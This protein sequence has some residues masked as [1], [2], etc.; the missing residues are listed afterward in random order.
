LEKAKERTSSLL[1]TLHF[2]HYKAVIDNDKL[3]KMH[4]VFVDIT[5]NSG[6]SP[7]RWQKGLTVMLEKKQ[8]VILVSKLRAILLM[9]ADFNFAHKT[10]F[11]C[12]MMHFAE[13]RNNIAGDCTGS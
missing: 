8:G 13:D 6:Y 3:N 2:G 4:A 11:G 5:I 9:E 1:S 12:R 10:I 7:K